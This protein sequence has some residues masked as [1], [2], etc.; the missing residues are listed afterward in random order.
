LPDERVELE[1]ATPP[2]PPEPG[3]EHFNIEC[4]TRSNVRRFLES[5]LVIG[6]FLTA[7]VTAFY[8]VWRFG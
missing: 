6:L 2:A 8:V 7:V 3:D 5:I 4:D 1:Y